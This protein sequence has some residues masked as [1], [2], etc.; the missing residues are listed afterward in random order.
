MTMYGT[1][2]DA[3]TYMS[4]NRVET[5]SWDDATD[6]EKTK[7]L[8]QATIRIERLRFVGLKTPAHN[9]YKLNPNVTEEELIAAAA[10]QEL[11]FPRG[12][13]TEV[14]A[15]IKKATYELAYAILDGIDEELEYSNVFVNSQNIGGVRLT[16][17]QRPP[18][19]V[20]A[21]IPSMVAWNYL[22]PYM[23]RPGGFDLRRVS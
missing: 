7:A 21:G 2:A 5:G 12:G 1:L 20:I 17:S 11:A 23:V 16:S 14:P 18:P 9:L 19:N 3:N 4:A 8:T 22:R 10:T 13:D 15:A 6:T